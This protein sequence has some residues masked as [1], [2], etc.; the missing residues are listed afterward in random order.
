MWLLYSPLSNIC[1]F[2]ILIGAFGVLLGMGRLP[3]GVPVICELLNEVTLD[4]SRLR[5]C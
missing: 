4:G 2:L 1:P 3:A 5:E